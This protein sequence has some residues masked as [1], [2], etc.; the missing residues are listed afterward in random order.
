MTNKNAMKRYLQV[1]IPSMI[2]YLVSL[3]SI[4]AFI[5]KS[6]PATAYNYVLPLIPAACV[7]LWMWSSARHILEVDEFVRHLHIKAV[8]CGLVILMVFTTAWGLLEFYTPIPDI[9]IFYAM[10]LFFGFYG[11]ASAVI[12]KRNNAGCAPQ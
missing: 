4:S 8:L 6:A 9:P 10:P 7:F 12:G 1:F 5:D 3:F 2:G 11:V